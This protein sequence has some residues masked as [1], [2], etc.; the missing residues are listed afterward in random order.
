LI[1][2]NN[3]YLINYLIKTVHACFIYKLVNNE[4]QIY[5]PLIDAMP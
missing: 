2:E 3:L 4:I 1:N 5:T